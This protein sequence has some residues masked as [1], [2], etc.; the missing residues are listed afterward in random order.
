MP[1]I[2]APDYYA[3]FQCTGPLCEDTCCNGSWN[4]SID[5]A[6]YQQ[7]QQS[8]H[9]V[10]APLFQLAVSKNTSASANN[11]H[12][13]GLLKMKPDGTC[14]FLQEDKLCAIHHHLGEQALSNTCRLYPRYLN[15]FGAQRENALGISCPE[16]ARLILL[17]PQPM[18]FGL[19]APTPAI[20]DRPFTSYRFPLQDEGEPAQMAALN[21]FRAVII[22]LL[23]CR[24]LSLGA[25]VMTL[26]F[27]LEEITRITSSAQFTHASALLPTL[28]VFVDMLAQP[29]QLEARF[30]QIQ[31]DMARKLDVMT[32]LISKSLALGAPPRFLECLLSAT[33]GLQTSPAVICC[34]STPRVTTPFTSPF[35]KVGATS[36]STIW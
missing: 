36:S 8:R 21:D 9:T 22:T 1:T 14:H 3:K 34:A 25:R 27:L 18:Q 6:T 12:N 24:D 26:G 17:N 4:V 5:H 15:Q 31:P 11:T 29:A 2:S 16:A 20:D 33:P 32:T 35:F 30:A 7:Y 13:F 10:L 19:I 28:G 23:Q